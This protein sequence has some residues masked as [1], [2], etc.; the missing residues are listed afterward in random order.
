M[1][2][3]FTLLI[4]LLLV[5]GCTTVGPE[6]DE[7]YEEKSKKSISLSGQVRLKIINTNG[8]ISIAD[9]D[10]AKS[11]IASITRRVR[12]TSVQDAQEHVNDIVLTYQ[13][14]S[15]E[16][17]IIVSHP[18]DDGRE[19]GVDFDI[20]LPDSFE[21]DIDMSYGDVSVQAITREIAVD[22]SGGNATTNVVLMDTC[23]VFIDIGN[24]NIALRLPDT[25]NAAINGVLINGEITLTGLT[26]N[27]QQLTETSISGKLGDGFGTITLGTGNGNIDLIKRL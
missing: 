12:S 3:L 11:I 16:I 10:T 25:T 24:G 19:Y 15:K 23:N 6:N 8:N 2:T 9:S 1:K 27:Y 4:A 21:Y 18:G 14:T 7:K 26:L 13:E 20:T 22:I 5:A 17:A